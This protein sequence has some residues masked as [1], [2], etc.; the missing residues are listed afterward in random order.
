MVP[1]AVR[2]MHNGEAAVAGEAAVVLNMREREDS[3]QVAGTPAVIGSIPA[4]SRLLLI[5]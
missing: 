4:G 1:H 5:A 2:Q 3:L